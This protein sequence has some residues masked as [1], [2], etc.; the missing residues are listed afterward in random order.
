MRA[1]VL[2]RPAAALLAALLMPLPALPS[3]ALAAT[4]D[5]AALP[6][7]GAAPLLLARGGGGG[8]SGGGGRGGFWAGRSGFQDGGGGL[9]RGSARPSGG[10]SS[11]VDRRAQAPSL[12]GGLDRRWPAAG[13]GVDRG[14][15]WQGGNRVNSAFD[16]NR[17][18]GSST[19]RNASVNAN[20]NRNVSF[21]NVNINAGWARPGWGY[22]RP[23]TTGWYGGWATPSWGWWAGT[24]A[25]WGIG[26]LATAAVINNAVNTAIAS[27]S[28]TIVVPESGYLLYY[29]SIQPSGIQGVTFVVSAGGVPYSLSADCYLGTLNGAIP[30]D[31]GQAQLLN[32][33]C[34]VAFGSAS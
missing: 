28:T 12:D 30:A 33:A 1:S 22:A 4:A 2:H 9:G 27:D 14:G 25:L 16:N 7:A 31:A 26:S 29:G 13:A 34:Q 15:S 10:W 17:I 21:N 24:A 18:D 6:P 19:W 5:R 11:A 23:W 3:R 8:L 32:A 20:W